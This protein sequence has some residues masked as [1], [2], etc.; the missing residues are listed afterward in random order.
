MPES[1]NL[2]APAVLDTAQ[3]AAYLGTTEGSLEADRVRRRW[4]VPFIRYGRAIKYLRSDL[5]AWLLAHRV[6]A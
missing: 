4:R 1:A 5:D 6:E 2:P 3:A